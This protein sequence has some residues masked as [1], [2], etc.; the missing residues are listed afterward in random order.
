MKYNGMNKNGWSA[1]VGIIVVG[2]EGG[3]GN[4]QV[5]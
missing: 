1:V 3:G 5:K 2:G 4:F